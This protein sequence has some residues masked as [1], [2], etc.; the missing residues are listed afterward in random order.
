VN[1]F[2]LKREPA[3]GIVALAVLA[4]LAGVAG[5]WAFQHQAEFQELHERLSRDVDEMV[6]QINVFSNESGT[7]SFEFNQKYVPL[8]LQE[9]LLELRTTEER[10]LY[11]SPR[12]IKLPPAGDGS[13]QD[14]HGDRHRFEVFRVAGFTFYLNADLDQDDSF[15]HEIGGGLLVAVPAMF[16]II[17]IGGLWLR[18]RALRP[19][20]NIRRGIAEMTATSLDHPIPSPSAPAEITDLV[21]ALN[22][23]FKDL[24]ASFEQA[25]RFSA[26]ASHQLKTPLAV[27]RLGIED[28]LTDPQTSNQQRARVGELLSQ[29]YRLTSIVEKLLLLSRADARRLSLQRQPFDFQHLL[30]SFL[31]DISALAEEKGITLETN[32]LAQRPIV[33]DSSSIALILENLMENAIKYNR[34]A[35]RIR[36]VVTENTEWTEVSVSNT[37]EPI[38]PERAPNIFQRFFRAHG[39]EERSGSG[40]GLSIARE[41]AEANRGQL[42]LVRSAG[43]WTEFRLRLPSR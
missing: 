41:L 17:M 27:L 5:M 4:L 14:A 21:S 28:L 39:G 26:D 33:G 12:I 25:A 3:V 30:S 42:E 9:R 32:I 2:N 40:L 13:Y 6:R 37:G 43:D 19:V 11:R 29:I 23:T 20:E 16:V 10:T 24:H 36:L 35:G 31:D 8:D 15:I 38:P 7:D 34:P 22:V 1:A 18:D